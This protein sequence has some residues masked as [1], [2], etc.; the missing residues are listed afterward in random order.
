MNRFFKNAEAFYLKC[1]RVLLYKFKGGC[2]HPPLNLSS[3]YYFFFSISNNST[4]KI[5]VENGLI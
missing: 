2:L 5:K 1:Q 3:Q 4:S